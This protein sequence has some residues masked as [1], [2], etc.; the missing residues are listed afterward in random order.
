MLTGKIMQ[1]NPET[2]H[3]VKGFSVHELT[4]IN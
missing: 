1:Y 2:G 3:R 4:R